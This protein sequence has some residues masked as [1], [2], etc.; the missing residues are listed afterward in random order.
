MVTA[1]VDHTVKLWDL[2]N[3]KD[4]NSFLHE[5]PH[6]MAVNSGTFKYGKSLVQLKQR[7]TR[8]KWFKIEHVPGAIDGCVF[9]QAQMSSNGVSDRSIKVKKTQEIKFCIQNVFIE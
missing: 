2:R 1:S 5:M 3:V 9:C 6:D 7:L 4:K 8:M